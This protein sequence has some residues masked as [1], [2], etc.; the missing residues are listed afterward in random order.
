LESRREPHVV[1]AAGL[2]KGKGVIVP[3]STE[4]A[5]VALDDMMLHRRFGDAGGTVLI[6]EKLSGP[7]VSVLALVDGRTILTLPPCQ[8]HK[9]LLE[10]DAGPNT[11]GMGAFCPSIAVTGELLQRVEREILVPTVDAMRQHGAEFT[12]VLY[13]GLM[14]TR[15][16]PRVL[17]FNVRFGDPECQPLM[18]LLESD[19][20]ELMLA[21]ASGTLERYVDADRPRFSTG[22]SVCVVLASEGYPDAPK[23]GLVIEGLDEAS[24]V[25]GVTV[26]HAGTRRNDRGEI[27]TSGGRV[28]GVTAVGDS[29]A[30]ARDRAYAACD[31]IHFDGMQLRRDISAGITVANA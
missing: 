9:R 1:K 23:T 28:L 18:A 5:L 11:G 26:Y 3:S 25:E 29:H 15:T 16:G 6:E 30:D 10:G 7:E 24:A 17:E 21:T 14:L 20:L 8:D 19:P 2:A 27:V 4:E 22:A 13:A 12:G 31:K